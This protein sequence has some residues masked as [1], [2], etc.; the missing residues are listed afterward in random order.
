MNTTHKPINR[1]GFLSGILKA[2]I[3]A[4]VLPSALTYARVWKPT[5]SGVIVP[6]VTNYEIVANYE[7]VRAPHFTP[8]YWDAVFARV[9]AGAGLSESVIVE[10]SYGRCSKPIL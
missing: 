10:M 6:I 5:A 1:R 3:G 9:C 4:M 8:E 2:G 7:I